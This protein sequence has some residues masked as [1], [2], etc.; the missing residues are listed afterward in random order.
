MY[1]KVKIPDFIDKEI[2]EKTADQ[3]LIWLILGFISK[4]FKDTKSW[5]KLFNS[6]PKGFELVS[7]TLSIL[8]AQV[9]NGGFNQFFYNGYKESTP[10][11]IKFLSTLGAVKHL[12]ILNK[13]IILHD[14]EKTNLESQK[15]YSDKSLETFFASYKLTHLNNLDDEWYSIE[16]ELIGLIIKY[17]REN[18]EQFITKNN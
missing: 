7:C 5:S 4:E 13:A 16:K 9:G 1:S 18:P 8:D 2:I 12:D 10:K 3:D 17:I 15:L 14:Q 6:L 11:L